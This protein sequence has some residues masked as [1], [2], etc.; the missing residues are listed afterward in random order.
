LKLLD[1]INRLRGSGPIEVSY[2][3]FK[4]KQ[5]KPEDV[6]QKIGAAINVQINLGDDQI[7]P[8]V[9]FNA[10]D[11][12]FYADKLFPYGRSGSGKEQSISGI[13]EAEKLLSRTDLYE[14]QLSLI[15]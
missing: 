9:P 6:L 1:Q 8:F 12:A 15:L 2:T 5:F 13:L 10:F 7:I 14:H 11:R 3:C 4:A